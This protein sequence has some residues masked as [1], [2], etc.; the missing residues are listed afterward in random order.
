MCVCVCMCVCVYLCEHIVNVC[1][2]VYLCEHIVSV[3]VCVGVGGV[4]AWFVRTVCV[5]SV[6]YQFLNGCCDHLM[7]VY[8]KY[9]IICRLA[10]VQTKKK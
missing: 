2:C 10:R 1:V 6:C 5:T 3:C 9:V 8:V 7:N 4:F